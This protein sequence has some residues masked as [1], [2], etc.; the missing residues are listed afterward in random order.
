MLNVDMDFNGPYA[1]QDTKFCVIL[2]HKKRT[3][4]GVPYYEQ[5]IEKQLM[6]YFSCNHQFLNF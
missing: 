4:K 2:S 5:A 1:I 3:P 6:K